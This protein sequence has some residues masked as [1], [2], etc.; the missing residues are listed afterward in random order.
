MNRIAHFEQTILPFL[1][2]TVLVCFAMSGNADAITPPPD[3]GYPG[4]NTAEG[5]NALQSLTTGGYNTAVGFSSL[6]S[7][8]TNSYNTAV[9]AGSLLANTADENTAIGAGALLVNGGSENTANGAFALFNNTTGNINT[10]IGAAA[11]SNNTTGTRNIAL[12]F[13]AGINVVS[14]DG[15]ICIGADGANVPSSCFIGNI[16]NI[17]P[18]NNDALPVVIDSTGQL[19]APASSRRYKTDIIPMNNRSE[20]VLALKPVSFRYKIHKDTNPQF[21]LIAEDVA[22]VNPDLVIYDSNGKPYAVRYE[23][24]NAMLL[25]EFLK[26]HRAFLQEQRIVEDLKKEV[27]AL[28]AG[29]QKVSAQVATA[30]PSVANLK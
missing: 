19:G 18:Q 29:L 21:G 4:G 11:L 28:T 30:S 2:A 25:N 26:E 10:A 13:A 17:T 7:N 1:A 8:S 22:K 5:H 23:A 9:G 15:V 24:V 3:G 20:S 12:G 27:K 16:R 6:G 14:A